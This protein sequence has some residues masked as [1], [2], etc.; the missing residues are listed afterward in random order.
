[1]NADSKRF[2]GFP[3][4]LAGVMVSDLA[5]AHSGSSAGWLHPLSG[6]DHLLAMIAVGAWSCQMGGKAIWVVP[7]AFVCCMLLGGLLGFD[8]IDLPGT[9]IGVSLSVVLL[10]LAIGLKKTFAVAVAALG[11]G[12]F[13]VFHGYAHGY[14]MPVMDDKFAYAAGFLT[15]TA[16]LHLIGAVG[17]WLILKARMGGSILRSLGFICAAAGAWLLATL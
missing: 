11:V 7:G 12:I 16:C 8:Q 13:G 10:G 14:E 17:A 4:L 1:M 5:Q 9:E 2:I 15:T 3:L 6:L